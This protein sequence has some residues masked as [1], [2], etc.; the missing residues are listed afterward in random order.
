MTRSRLIALTLAAAVI[1]ATLSALPATAAKHKGPSDE[2]VAKIKAA[3]ADVKARVQPK[4]PRRLLVFSVS[5][6]YFHSSIPYGK[7]AIP[8][9]GEA[10][11][12]FEATVSDDPAMFEPDRLETFDAVFFN[13]ANRDVFRPANF[14]DLPPEEKK[15]VERRD[16]HLKASFRQWLAAGHGVAANHA[17]CNMFREWPE[18]GEILGSRFWNHPWG[19][20]STVIM[21]VEEP[22]HPLCQ[23]L[24]KERFPIVDEVYQLNDPYSRDLCRVLVS[25]DTERTDMEKVRKRIR[26]TD[27]DF[28]MTY[29]K[30]YKQ[31]R[32]FYNAWGH[33]HDLFWNPMVLQHWL[34]GIQ[35]AL[36][37]L[38]ADATP[39]AK[40]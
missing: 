30:T 6:G 13:N 4:K 31:G 2:E 35:Y 15:Q 37:D 40:K 27:G 14:K 24:D 17:A 19:A 12:A 33:M 20:G 36:G 8:L 7:A 26:R 16:A 22:N 11:G 18:F 23:A 5:H 1:V 29:I 32:V 25:I 10:T 28:A 34:D 9:L 3:C 38:E 39:S 21:K